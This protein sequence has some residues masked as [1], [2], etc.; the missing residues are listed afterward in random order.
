MLTASE[1]KKTTLDPNSRTLDTG[2]NNARSD[3]VVNAYGA[4]ITT[5][6]LIDRLIDRSRWT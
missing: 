3:F 4:F 1:M 6:R 5:D 2:E